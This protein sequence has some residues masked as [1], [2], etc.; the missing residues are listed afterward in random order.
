MSRPHVLIVGAG[1]VFGS[2]LARLL[3]R[4]QLFRLSLGGRDAGR[5]AALQA[6]LRQIDGQGEYGFVQIDRT[7]AGPDLLREL[8]CLVVVDCAGP[9]QGSSTALIEAAIAARCNYIDIADSRAF[10]AEISRFDAAAKAAGIAVLTGASTTPALSHAVIESIA[11][12]WRQIDSID[13]AIAPGN[14]APKGRAV[15]AAIL[16]WVGQPVRVFREGIWQQARGWSGTRKVQIDGLTSRRVALA[17]V[18]DL[19]LM[20]SRFRPRVRAGFEA[21][22][23]LGL[24]HGSVGLAG[25]AVRLKLVRSATAFAGLGTWVANLLGRVG[26]DTGGML[27]EVAGLDQ[28]LETKVV[29]WSLKATAGD[30]PYVPVLAAAAA[31]LAL[32]RGRHIVGAQPAVGL[33]SLEDIKAWT[34]GLAIE[35]KTASFKREVPLYARVMGPAFAALPEVTQRLHRGRPALIVEGQ[36]AVIGARNWAGRLVAAMFG[37]PREASNVP[38]RVVIEA[39]DGREYWTRFFDGKPMRSVMSRADEGV[40]EERF[41]AIA[42]CMVL[43]PR[44]DG[45]DMVRSSGRIGSIPIPGFLLPRIKAEERVEGQRHRFDVDIA[46]PVI[47]RLVAYRG[48]LEL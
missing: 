38:V 42:I 4:R 14:R 37:M 31:V 39:R 44:A 24:I 11:A 1:G 13:V 35:T 5:V 46:L 8:A 28:R 19:D 23:E 17:E 15:I 27:V 20:A 43:V 29:R 47:G 26:T 6:E 7:S 2:R 16:S 30:G 12:G 41:G 48:W 25:L 10:V 45:L 40:I 36:A 22:M 34:T 33:L 9:F 21:G 3:A 18:P 32:A